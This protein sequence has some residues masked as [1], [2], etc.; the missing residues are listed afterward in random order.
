MPPSK[1]ICDLILDMLKSEEV[2][3]GLIIVL[4]LI[5]FRLRSLTTTY[6]RLEERGARL[7]RPG[8]RSRDQRRD[9]RCFSW[10][11]DDRPATAHVCDFN[12]E[13]WGSR[14]GGMI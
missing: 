3:S 1:G 5:M 6:T 14:K 13:R 7:R 8:D 4:F 10:A 9:Q 12:L 2:D 11:G